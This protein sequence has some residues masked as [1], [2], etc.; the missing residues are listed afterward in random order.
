MVSLRKSMTVAVLTYAALLPASAVRADISLKKAFL[1]G[2]NQFDNTVGI[3]KNLLGKGYDFAAAAPY[4][5]QN[6]NFGFADLTLGA[7]SAT[8]VRLAAGYTTRGIPTATFSLATGNNPLSYVF[9]IDPGF[10]NLT[11]AGN[12]AINVN[13]KINALGFYD[14]TFQI[15]NRGTYT[16]KGW[17]GNDQQS[18]DFDAGPIVVSGNIYTD[19]AAA[20][21]KPFFD[22]VGTFNP[23]EK[24]SSRSARIAGLDASID[25]LNA[26]LVTGHAL[27]SEETNTLVNNTILAALLGE[28]PSSHL[29]DAFMVPEGLLSDGNGIGPMAVNV[30]EPSCLGLLIVGLL[31][32]RPSR[33]S[34]R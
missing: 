8:T 26:K 28:K 15:S 31:A 22:A 9:Q 19:A 21:T 14:Q 17:L 13:T 2:L 11:A 34:R 5:G 1:I 33:R 6:Y 12:V 27:T 24:L 23:F 3:E 20:V 29:F 16:A 32:L 4:V 30:P 25:A 7:T 10:Q 18:L